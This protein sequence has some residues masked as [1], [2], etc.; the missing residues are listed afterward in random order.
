MV[1]AQTLLSP[2]RGALH[3]Y[4]PM[5][6]LCDALNSCGSCL[7]FLLEI[8]L[9]ACEGRLQGM[10]LEIVR[11]VRERGSPVCPVRASRVCCPTPTPQ[12]P[13]PA[14]CLGTELTLSPLFSLNLPAPAIL[15]PALSFQP[16]SVRSWPSLLLGIPSLILSTYTNPA[17]FLWFI[18]VSLPIGSPQRSPPIG[19]ACWGTT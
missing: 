9:C 8:I 7:P 12:W 10:A 14:S 4:L 3:F 1:L 17:I 19:F 2:S 18:Q 5:R 13:L 16:L 6:I 15:C 11:R